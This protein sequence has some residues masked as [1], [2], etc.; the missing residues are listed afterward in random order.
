MRMRRVPW[1]RSPGSRKA[2]MLIV[3]WQVY[4]TICRPSLPVKTMGRAG[5]MTGDCIAATAPRRRGRP[6]RASKNVQGVEPRR[7][8]ARDVCGDDGDEHQER[9]HY[10]KGCRIRSTHA[11][12]ERR[13]H[14]RQDEAE[15]DADGNA[16]ERQAHAFPNDQ[17]EH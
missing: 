6:L 9:R 5:P 7:A 3:P 15:D 2:G 8:T 11:K 17:A 1:S 14:A 16:G 12:D 4:M 10:T 13:H